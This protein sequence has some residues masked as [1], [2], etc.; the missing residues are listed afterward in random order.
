V[1]FMGHMI[2]NLICGSVSKWGIPLLWLFFRGKMT[3]QWMELGFLVWDKAE[4]E[5][6]IGS[7][8]H[9]SCLAMLC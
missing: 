6:P 7:T 2:I 9:G 3:N 8:E 1:D 5:F 4:S